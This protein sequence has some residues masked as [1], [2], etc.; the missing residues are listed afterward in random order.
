MDQTTN[1]GP[2]VALY[3]RPSGAIMSALQRG[4][5]AIEKLASHSSIR[6]FVPS[7]LL[8]GLAYEKRKSPKVLYSHDH[9]VVPFG[10]THYFNQDEKAWAE[11]FK[12]NHYSL[13][14]K[15]LKL[16]DLYEEA[17]QEQGNVPF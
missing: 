12:K 14:K 9:Q 7:L 6:E 8:D 13:L 5:G 10:I 4:D 1:K 2:D 15:M 16:R 3:F 17:K 11:S